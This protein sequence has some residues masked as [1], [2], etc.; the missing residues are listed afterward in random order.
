MENKKAEIVGKRWS[1]CAEG[2]DSIIQGEFEGELPHKWSSVLKRHAPKEGG[3][4][5]D[6]GTGPGF[7]AVLLAKMGWE[8]TG[9]D[10]AEKMVET[11]RKNAKAAGV[12]AD[13]YQMDNH[14]L[15]FPDNTFDYI[16]SRNVT[17]I[18]Y[19]PEKAFKEWLRILKPG[20]RI[21]YF[22]ANW[23]YT[24]DKAFVEAQKA[25][26]EAYRKLYG[27]PVNTYRGD[28]E[29]EREF[30]T[31]LYFNEIWRPDWDEAHLPG[32]GYCNVQVVQRVNEEVYNEEK[33]LLYRSIPM[34]LVTADKPVS[35]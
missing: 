29:T 10:C 17:W 22:D 4:A 25:D 28:E 5:L 24:K 14:Q 7:F 6:I 27:E 8:I 9:I 16:V 34:F 3:R 2:Y 18:L 1:F 31:L 35:S 33:G 20:G 19:E 21:L 15:D 32:C 11:A 13:F 30:R 23:H 26:E 12:Q